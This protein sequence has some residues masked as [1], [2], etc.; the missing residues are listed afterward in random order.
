MLRTT[1]VA[2]QLSGGHAENAL[3]QRARAVINC[4][5]LPDEDARAVVARLRTA[6]D[7]TTLTLTPLAEAAPAAATEMRQ[8][9]IDAVAATARSV[10]G[11]LPVIPVMETGGTDGVHTRPAGLPT[12]GVS[13]FFIE[14][15]ENR[16]HGRDERIRARSFDDGAEF[17]Y[18]LVQRLAAP[19]P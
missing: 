2:T 9:L 17:L 4:R 7:D 18:R 1:C 8:E 16:M 5:L 13:G 6:I 15:G 11:P 3:P 12:F 10:W 19:T 14:A